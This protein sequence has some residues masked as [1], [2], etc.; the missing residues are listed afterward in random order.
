M[1]AKK[2]FVC[3]SRA[4][5]DLR[6]A[7][8]NTKTKIE[9]QTDACHRDNAFRLVFRCWQFDFPDIYGQSRGQRSFCR[10]DRL[11]DYGC[12]TSAFG[13]C[14]DWHKQ[15]RRSYR[16]FEQSR[17]GLRDFLHMRVV[18]DDRSVFCG[19]SLCDRSFHRRRRTYARKRR[20]RSGRACDF[21]RGVFH[22]RAC[23]FAVPRQN[24]HLGGANS[25]SAVSRFSC[26]SRHHRSCKAYGRRFRRSRAGQLCGQSVHDG[27][28][29][30]LQH[31]GR[32][33]KF[34]I[35]HRRN[36]RY[37]KT[38]R[39]RAYFRCEK[40]SQIRLIVLRI[41]GVDISRRCACGRT[42]WRIVYGCVERRR[43]FCQGQQLLF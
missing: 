26:R 24:S 37:S 7:R 36:R 5:G 28:F 33:C 30:R 42:K 2:S 38:G 10:F 22:R 6:H 13:R 16:T 8:R 19:A 14:G 21:Q 35:R 17:Q 32:S 3:F 34:G 31:V 23:L 40:H 27:I 43:D 39:I 15:K 29:G 9:F 1:H 20:Q 41:Y 25:H 18:S 4:K 12:R 11:F